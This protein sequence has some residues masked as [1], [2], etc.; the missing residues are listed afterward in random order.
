M[1]HSLQSGFGILLL[2]AG[3]ADGAAADDPELS[4]LRVSFQNQTLPYIRNYC[5]RCHSGSDPEAKLDLA[6]FESV[7]SVATANQTWQ[8]VMERILAADMPPPDADV[9][10]VPGESEKIVRWIQEVREFEARRH[11]GDPGTVL[12]RRL[13]NA[14]YDYTIRDLTG[15]DIRPTATFPV[16][17]ANEAGFDNSG[18]SL[19]MSPALLD[20]YL[21]AA[22]SVVEHMALTPDGIAFA[23]HPVVTDTDRDK[24]CVKR[25]VQFYEQQPTDLAEYFLAA[26]QVRTG[27]GEDSGSIDNRI[28]QAAEEQKLSQRYLETVWRFLHDESVN[29]GPAVEIRQRWLNLPTEFEHRDN[30][31]KQ[32]TQ[33]RDD[34]ME[35]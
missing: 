24:Y 22:R 5:V 31:R 19:T 21:A 29:A 14:E 28:R 11:A 27:H 16:D 9:Q 15:V 32:C 26:W 23:P 18:E 17:P 6:M 4:D 20:K 7:E 25:I 30:V 12:V 2:L 1:K 8:I 10:P 34:V 33:L 13:S 35:L 3:W